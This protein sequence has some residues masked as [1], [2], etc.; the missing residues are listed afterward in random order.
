M[1]T[2]AYEDADKPAE[3]KWLA[4]EGRWEYDTADTAEMAERCRELFS[5][6]VTVIRRTK[7][8]EGPFVITDHV[9][10][11]TFEPEP[12]FVRVKAVVSCAEP[13]VNPDLLTA[14][15]EQNLPNAAPDAGRFCR[16]AL[17]RENGSPYR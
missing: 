7:R 1:V 9:R 2:D 13:V 10:E 3:V 5:S 16:L 4:C 12:G 11:L 8:G 15:V 6:P 14:A 17:Y